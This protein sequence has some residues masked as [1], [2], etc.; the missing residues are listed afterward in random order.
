MYIPSELGY[1]ENGSPPKIQ[2]GDALVFTME[3]IKIN[4][5][6][7]P[8]SRCDPSD[9]NKGCDEQEIKHLLRGINRA[10]ASSAYDL[11][12]GCF[13]ENPV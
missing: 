2:G 8:A 13:P 5:N 3:V 11:H 6:K 9:G 4:G 1:G 10:A 12:L 7:V